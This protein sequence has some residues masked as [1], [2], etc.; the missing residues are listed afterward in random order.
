MKFPFKVIDLTHEISANIPTWDINC[1]FSHE[2][3]L[4]YD[5][6]DTDVKF[7]VQHAE[8]PLGIGTHVDAP[9]HC[10]VNGVT[11]ESL[12]LNSLITECIVINVSHLATENYIV[13]E[14]V[15]TQF[16]SEYKKIP[17]NS[18]VIVY[19]GWSENW[20]NPIKYHNNY[21]F[22]SISK[23]V[24]KTLLKREI[25]GLGIDT[26]SPDRHKLFLSNNKYIVEN[27]NKANLLPYINSYIMI[28]P[29]KIKDATEAPAR[30]LGLLND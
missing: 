8:M 1:G 24:A 11:I 3:I 12:E 26:L 17:K 10:C 4:D 18:F 5:D 2:N 20:N 29:M 23:D 28:L 14:N 21:K 6:C 9:A 25:A 30:I 15:I 19:T 22:P 27:I 16:E 7:R 13:D